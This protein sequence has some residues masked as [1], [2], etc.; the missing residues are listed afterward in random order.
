MDYGIENISLTTADTGQTTTGAAGVVHSIDQLQYFIEG[1]EYGYHDVSF[2][3][4]DENLTDEYKSW[5]SYY[6]NDDSHQRDFKILLRHAE[7]SYT[8]YCLG[9]SLN[10]HPDGSSTY[11]Y[12]TAQGISSLFRLLTGQRQSRRV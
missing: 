6:S 10:K 1:Y 11:E 2:V 8:N 7:Y 9:F 4:L 3:L 12:G 5:K